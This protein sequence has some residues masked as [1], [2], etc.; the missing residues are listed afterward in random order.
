MPFLTL[1]L[2]HKE[3][4]VI[5]VLLIAGFLGLEY[6]KGLHSEV[7]ELR[8]KNGVLEANLETSNKSIKDLQSAIATQNAA[9]D[10]MKA[11][12][13]ARQQAHAVEIASA[14]SKADTYRKQALDILMIKPQDPDKC[15]A[16]NDLVNGEILKSVKK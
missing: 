6:V 12:A 4:I 8:T 5:V 10:K 7:T 16:A 13:D 1:L 14:N 11:D 9:V 3:F 15:K 2:E